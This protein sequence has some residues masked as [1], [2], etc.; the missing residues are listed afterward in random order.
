MAPNNMKVLLRL[1]KA[2]GMAGSNQM[3]KNIQRLA[4]RQGPA[5]NVNGP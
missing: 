3:I 2:D 5:H 1:Y 4:N